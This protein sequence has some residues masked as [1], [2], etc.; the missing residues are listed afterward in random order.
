M[1]AEAICRNDVAGETGRLI[2]R[3]ARTG[4]ERIFDVDFDAV[5]SDGL[6]EI[7]LPL[8]LG[9]NANARLTVRA[10]LA[11]VF[12]IDEE[13]KLVAFFV[14]F[15]PRQQDRP[16]EIPTDVFVPVERAIEV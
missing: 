4:L 13:E 2:G 15:R 1:A 11:K 3:A 16:A 12:L 9:R 5:A 8:G 10:Q 14:E 7:A 6:R